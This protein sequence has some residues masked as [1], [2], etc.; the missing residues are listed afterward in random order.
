MNRD[1]CPDCTRYFARIKKLEETARAVLYE[2]GD[3]YEGRLAPLREL[4][5]PEEPECG[6]CGIT[7]KQL[8]AGYCKGCTCL[9]CNAHGSMNEAGWCDACEG[10]QIKP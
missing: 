1:D 7:G 8:I 10:K 5:D 3:E 4:V 6:N 2:F 9:R